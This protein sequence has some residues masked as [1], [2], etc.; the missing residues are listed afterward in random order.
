MGT[1]D[2][3]L[4]FKLVSLW[5]R[6]LIKRT[7]FHFYFL[8]NVN[9]SGLWTLDCLYSVLRY[10]KDHSQ[11]FIIFDLN[12]GHHM[13]TVRV[14]EPNFWKKLEVADGGNPHF[15]AVSEFWY[16]WIQ[17]FCLNLPLKNLMSWKNLA[18]AAYQ[19]I[20]PFLYVYTLWQKWYSSLLK[21]IRFGRD[22][23]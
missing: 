21:D 13:G 22:I 8:R 19:Q 18:L 23:L 2:S 7:G 11:F 17:S 12:S 9:L 14:T 5:L 6:V 3:M 4:H 1:S 16:P 15:G 10:L 20:D